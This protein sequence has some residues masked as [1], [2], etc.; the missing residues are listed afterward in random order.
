[1]PAAKTTLLA[2]Q[3]RV[4]CVTSTSKGQR[5][6]MHSFFSNSYCLFL[7]TL[8]VAS[9][10]FFTLQAHAQG[11]VSFANESTL[12]VLTVDH[13]GQEYWSTFWLVVIEGKMY[14]R[15]GGRGAARIEGNTKQPFV[16]VKLAGRRFDNVRVISEPEMAEHVAAAMAQKYPSDL[17]IRWLPHPLTVRLERES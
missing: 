17:I 11:W 9:L 13:N 6:G 1:M 4:T 8:V 14:L 12:E 16:S 7:M 2:E 3:D 10:R 15:L 5:K